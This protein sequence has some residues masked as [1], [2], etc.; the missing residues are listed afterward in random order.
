MGEVILKGRPYPKQIDFFKSTNKYIAYGGAR[1]GGKSWAARRK[2]V[3]LAL[4]YPGIQILLIRRTLKDLR[5]N[6]E[7]PLMS[8]LKDIA[9][10]SAQNKEF[11]FPNG[12][13]ICLGY[14]DTENDVLQ[15]QGQSYDVIF[16]EEATQFTEFQID[17]LTESNRRSPTMRGDF[18]SRMYY[19]CNPG[20]P[21]HA[22]I[23]R[24]FIDHDYK[25]SERPEDYD[26]IPSSVYE[27]DYL[28]QNDPDYVRTLENL[29]EA[30]R[31]AML[32][33]DWDA[34]EGQYFDEFKRDIH[35][36]EPIS[37]PD[38]WRRYITIDYGLDMLAAY[39]IAV[40]SQGK[41]HVYKEKYQDGLIISDAAQ[42]IKE[43]TTE[44]I[45]QRLAPPD[46]WNR[47]Q[48]T[49][50]SAADLFREN[51]VS[52]VKANNNRIQGWYNLKEWLK[53]YED[54]Q[55]IKTAHLVIFKTCANIIRCLP[56]LQHDEKDPND[57]A[58]EPHELTHGPDAIR[59]FIAGRPKPNMQRKP[60][61]HYNFD[62]ERKQAEK[63]R[64]VTVT[65]D[66]F[67]GGY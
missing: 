23:K 4:N 33:G 63:N 30:R 50:K 8:E 3:L 16:M 6:H 17:C 55:G 25:A 66:F 5:K 9:K 22:R 35:V 46:L 53:P 58:N 19:T 59:Y 1:G 28:M 36:I 67:K 64:G 49:G 7:L 54:E 61:P 21:G 40:N 37:I 41:A 60:D 2:A 39:W 47:R 20:G 62:F 15:Y 44:K 18:T 42:A 29:P 12:A 26:F 32:Y 31:K 11:H 65:E 45:Y 48:E 43:M 27:N 56:L 10:Y 13:M 51:G 57:V 24:L 38:D 52:L 14:C 34:F